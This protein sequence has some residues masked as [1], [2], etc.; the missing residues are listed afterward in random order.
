VIPI[1][2]Y[3]RF[4]RVYQSDIDTKYDMQICNFEMQVVL[5]KIVANNCTVFEYISDFTVAKLFVHD[6]TLVE[7]PD[8]F[9]TVKS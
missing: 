6:N 7:L 1:L 9:V 2:P 3:D 4:N 5:Y 8:I